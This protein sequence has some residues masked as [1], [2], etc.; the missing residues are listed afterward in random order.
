MQGNIVN[1][2]ISEKCERMDLENFN[3]R[4]FTFAFPNVHF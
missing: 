3:N 1:K 4:H 2:V